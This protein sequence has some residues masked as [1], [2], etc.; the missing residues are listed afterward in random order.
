MRFPSYMCSFIRYSTTSYSHFFNAVFISSG[1]PVNAKQGRQAWNE[2]NYAISNVENFDFASDKFNEVDINVN[3][4]DLERFRH[5][6]VEGE[7]KDNI[8]FHED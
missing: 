7:T 8:L 6:M 3:T 5:P 4:R 2:K 1:T